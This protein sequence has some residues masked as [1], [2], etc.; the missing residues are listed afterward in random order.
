MNNHAVRALNRK[1]ATVYLTK[2]STASV[3]LLNVALTWPKRDQK[4]DEDI[5]EE[6]NRKFRRD[7][8]ILWFLCS[9]T[10]PLHSFSLFFI[11]DVFA[12][13]DTRGRKKFSV[14]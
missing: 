6:L 8:K 2:L 13:S 5:R 10:S 12:E 9:A 7:K 14:F 11:P 3:G 1:V 4:G